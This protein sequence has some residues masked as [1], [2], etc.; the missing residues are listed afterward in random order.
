MFT[1]IY[2]DFKVDNKLSH[3]HII[4]KA[5]SLRGV[6][7]P[8]TEEE[9]IRMLKSVGFKKVEVFSNGLILAVY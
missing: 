3:S 4:N 2:Y 6:M 5:R 9:N 7:K 1:E 8:S